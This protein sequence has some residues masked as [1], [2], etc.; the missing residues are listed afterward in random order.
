MK[1]IKLLELETFR[2]SNAINIMKLEYQESFYKLVHFISDNKQTLIVDNKA[3]IKKYK[4]YFMKDYALME[5]LTY[6][7]MKGK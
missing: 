4:T 1:Y 5:K 2:T 6:R 7:V 3:Y